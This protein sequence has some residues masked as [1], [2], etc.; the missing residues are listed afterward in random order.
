M[1]EQQAANLRSA[2]KLAL[3]RAGL[4]NLNEANS[5][6][7]DYDDRVKYLRELAAVILAYP[8]RFDEQTVTSARIA[9]GK[10]YAPL[11]S[12]SF[13]DAVVDAYAT[14]TAQVQAI[15]PLSEQNREKTRNVIIGAILLAA[16]VFFGVLAARNSPTRQ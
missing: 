10:N 7:L 14:A 4:D 15:N 8:A 13:A 9:Q 2:R 5:L 1:T 6:T 16:V 3:A 11:E 12:Y